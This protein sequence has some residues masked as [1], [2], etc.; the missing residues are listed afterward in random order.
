M[1]QYLP[2]IVCFIIGGALGWFLHVVWIHNPQHIAT[3]EA[4]VVNTTDQVVA[5]L[6]ADYNNAVTAINKL[7]NIPTPPTPP[8]PPVA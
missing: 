3:A 6:V 5:K 4:Q 8:V 2:Y 7:K 1:E